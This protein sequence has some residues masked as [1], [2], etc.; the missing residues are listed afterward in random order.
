MPLISQSASYT[1]NYTL[2]FSD[3][4]L[5]IHC[6]AKKTVQKKKHSEVNQEK[7]EMFVHRKSHRFEDLLNKESPIWS[8]GIGKS[9]NHRN[10]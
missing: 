4:N 6:L 3:D 10:E 1:S 9:I 8:K 2:R 7:D 5:A